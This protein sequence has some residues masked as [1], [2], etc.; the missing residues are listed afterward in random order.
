MMAW[1]EVELNLSIYVS[2][3]K[4]RKISGLLLSRYQTE[5]ENTYRIDQSH[6]RI[7]RKDFA[8]K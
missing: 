1:V 7:N 8:P 3:N 2:N 4:T 6:A 5:V